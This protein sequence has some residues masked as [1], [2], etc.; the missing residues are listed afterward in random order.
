MIIIMH[1]TAKYAY[2]VGKADIVNAFNKGTHV[3][4]ENRDI[5]SIVKTTPQK[6]S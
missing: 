1:K 6:S 4:L 3:Q 2:I 5:Y